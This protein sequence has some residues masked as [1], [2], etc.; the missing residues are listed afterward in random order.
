MDDSTLDALLDESAPPVADRDAVLL[1][2][3]DE[4]V[5]ATGAPAGRRG[6]LRRSVAA[7]LIVAG[8][9]GLGTVAAAGGFFP[10]S[11]SPWSDQTFDSGQSCRLRFMA[12]EQTEPAKLAGIS[13]TEQ[14]EAVLA[15]QA[16]LD[17][18]DP[19]SIDMQAA[20]ADLLAA[21]AEANV[22]IPEWDRAPETQ[23]EMEVHALIYHT[24]VE[25]RAALDQQGINP[26]AADIKTT[27][28]CENP[29]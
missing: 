17:T 11:W 14:R 6:G 26:N 8:T 19:T 7:G 10:Q 12:G 3:L 29:K 22:N 28:D 1:D 20:L 21:Q 18:F 24:G 16:F 2:D 4:L 27:T 5:H 25:L 13:K 15:A 9:L 23:E